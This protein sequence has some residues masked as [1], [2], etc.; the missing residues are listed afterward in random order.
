MRRRKVFFTSII[1]LA[2]IVMCLANVGYCG[3]LIQRAR[4][5]FYEGDYTVAEKLWTGVEEQGEY[6]WEANFFL[7]MTYLRTDDLNRALEHMSK[8]YQLRRDNFY[9]LVNYARI[10]YR[11]NQLASA[12]EI[13]DQVP[14][15]MRE[16]NE[17]YFNIRGL[18]AMARRN[19][20]EAV[21]MF[22]TAVEIN[23]KSIYVQNNLG[24]AL[25]RRGD[26][27]LARNHLEQAVALEPSMPYVYNNL[28]ISYENLGLL[29]KA[30]ESYQ[31][32]L[33]LDPDYENA[34]LNLQRVVSK[35]N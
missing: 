23:P 2:F 30:K 32:A 8:A 31:R 7:G 17:Q 11:T 34:K 28:G 26:F 25:I 10:L 33:E 29:E 18:V 20:Q 24:L 4:Q 15:G 19:L 5:A 12:S 3:D 21:E 22:S 9:T 27:F 13:L 6:E 16:Y 14:E 1:L 35:L